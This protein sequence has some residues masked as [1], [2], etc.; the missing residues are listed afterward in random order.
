MSHMRRREFI[1][2]LGG[3]AA[4]P[5][6]AHAQRWPSQVVRI[7]CPIAAGGGEMTGR[8]FLRRSTGRSRDD[9]AFYASKIQVALRGLTPRSC[10][11]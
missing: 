11:A 4:W 9:G 6:A 3:A 7:I 8:R 5:L 1:T 2:L 10:F